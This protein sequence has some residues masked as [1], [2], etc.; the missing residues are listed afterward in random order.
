MSKVLV[1]GAGVGGATAAALLAKAGHDVTVLEAH[2]YAGG[3]AGTFYHQKYRFDAGATLAGGFHEG[4]PHDVVGK[5]LGIN[6]KVK[7]VNPAW[8][9]MMPD[10]VVTQYGDVQLWHEET[11]RAFAGSSQRDRILHFLRDTERISDAVWDFASRRPAWPPSNIADLFRTATALRPKTFI[12]LPHVFESMGA[13]A[14]RAGISDRA[15]LTFL[16]AQLLIS[17]QTTSDH[18]SALFGAAATDLPRK[19]VTHPEGGIGGISAQLVEAIHGFGGQVH[20]RQEVTR[21]ETKDGR[22]IAAHTNKGARFE[23]D[24]C[25]ANLT[26]WDMARLLGHAAPIKLQNEIQR[27]P[28]EWGA[29]TLYLGVEEENRDWRLE[30]EDSRTQSPFPNL[31]SPDHV[32]VVASYDQPVGETNSIFMSFSAQG[33][34][35]RAPAGHRALTISTHMRLADWWKLRETPGAQREYDERVAEYSERM[36]DNAEVAVPGLRKRIRLQLAGTP[37]TFKFYTRR[38]RGGVGGFPFT[39]L[40]NARGPWTGMKNAW[41]VGD[42][43]FPGQSTAG[44][45]MGALRVADEVLRAY[46]GAKTTSLSRPANEARKT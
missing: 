3:C 9:V 34:V 45:T 2:V 36:L 20:F 42:S 25:I 16:D 30:N 37:V 33:D 15:A 11:A 18:A 39:S 10:R 7:P 22:I 4:G 6:W 5:L 27:L 17:A 43:I 24:V 26:P 38:H 44:V 31:Q 21:F 23:C 41:L 35:K 40:F 29:F 19:G 46:P 32:Q 1:V 13:W 14:R 8:Q 12:T 28:D